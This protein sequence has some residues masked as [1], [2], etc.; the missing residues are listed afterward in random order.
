MPDEPKIN[1][2]ELF[3]LLNAH[4]KDLAWYRAEVEKMRDWSRRKAVLRTERGWGQ[5][6]LN[7]IKR[8][9]EGG[10]GQVGT[11]IAAHNGGRVLGASLAAVGSQAAGL[12]RDADTYRKFLAANPKLAE[13]FLESRPPHLRRAILEAAHG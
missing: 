1:V 7:W 10:H 13:S 6:A 3:R 11:A 4:N 5:F 9:L 2:Q 8:A 12:A